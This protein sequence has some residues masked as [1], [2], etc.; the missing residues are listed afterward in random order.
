VNLTNEHIN[1]IIKDLHHRGIIY[2]GLQE[3]LID[4]IC[5]G[6]EAEMDGGKK[7][8]DAY[9]RELKAFGSTSGLRTVQMQ[10][11]KVENKKTKIMLRNYLTIALRSLARHRLYTGINVLGLAIGIAACLI[12]VLYVMHEL[13]YDRYHSKADHIFR[14]NNEIWIGDNHHL[15]ATSAPPVARTLQETYP[16]IESTVRLVSYGTYLVNAGRGEESIKEQNVIWAD[17]TFFQIFDVHLLQGDPKTAL[18]DPYSIAISKRTADKYFPQGNAIGNS[19]ILDNVYHTNVT[20]V[21]EDLPD[22]S[23]FHFDIIISMYGDW[24]V[25][26]EALQTDFENKNFH[27]Y[28]LLRKGT[29][30]HDL[31]AKFPG[32]VKK[33]IQGNRPSNGN[34]FAMSLIPVTDIHLFGHWGNELEGN[35]NVA[36]V[37]LF[38]CIALLILVVACIN[39]TNMATA[40]SGDRAKEVGVRKVMGSLRSHLV[41]QFLM[42]ST[43]LTAFAFMLA[44]VIA[45]LLMPTFNFLSARALV[46]PF[47]E[48][49]FYLTLLMM[50]LV[51]G[52]IAGAYPSFFL[53]SF[54]P[55]HVL[56]GRLSQGV[57]PSLA[58]SVLV[59]FQFIISILLIIGAITVNQQLN[60]IQEK[61]MGFEKD[62]VLIIKD[63]YALRP[64]I[65]SY[66]NQLRELTG[67]DN[68]SITAFVPVE[69]PEASRGDRTSWKH[70]TEPVAENFVSLQDWRVDHEY[71]KTMG[72]EILD[73]R[74]FSRQFPSDQSAI[75][76]NQTAVSRFGLG[77]DPIGKKINTFSWRNRKPDFAHPIEYTVIGVVRDFHF[78]SLK[79]TI[80][81]LGLHL[82]QSDGFIIVKLHAQTARK[83]IE[84]IEKVWKDI[85]PLQPFQF[86]FL[87]EDFE[88]MYEAEVRLGSIFNLF[89]TLAILLACLGLFALTAYTAQ[90]RTKEIGIRKVL[91]AT[92]SNIV[93]MLSKDFGKLILISCIV[94]APFAWYAVNRWLENY[95]YKTVIGWSV[96]LA[97]GGTALIIGLLTMSYQSLKAASANPVDSLRNE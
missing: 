75:I 93:L 87:E 1:Y 22:A 2:E 26:K 81:P 66:K 38:G 76:I 49:F 91:G 23:H 42:E 30:A 96:Y 78:S 92:V 51:I 59:V 64:N 69:N 62:Q 65:E 86:S 24:P 84:S 32:Y 25:A 10:T 48:P 53:S 41:R 63:A 29:S 27:T 88:R 13:S 72:M 89:A 56:K 95:T 60:F 39:F 36:Y 90:Q 6:V 7:F 40:R 37:Y 16:E 50:I 19:L 33:Y 77:S 74:D 47:G 67:V 17:S 61:N 4:H 94:S 21:Y 35:S 9:H 18:K 44:V 52:F 20:A 73:G 15:L 14:V 28:L 55:V 71:I 57:K 34:T 58:R 82:G 8:I 80:E 85:A 83:T 97:A 70:G 3:E 45:Y 43:V 31:E 68:V 11:L 12:I 46:I 79:E 54:R 5:S